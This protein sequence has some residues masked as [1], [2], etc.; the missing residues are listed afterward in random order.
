MFTFLHPLSLL[1]DHRMEDLIE[2]CSRTLVN[3]ELS[4]WSRESRF[5]FVPIVAYSQLTF[6]AL[7]VQ[8]PLLER[9]TIRSLS[10][11]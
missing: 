1:T 7:R 4:R 2:A 10:C 6:P 8:L 3:L 11:L 9:I 5:R